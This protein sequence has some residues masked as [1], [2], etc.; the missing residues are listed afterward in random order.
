MFTTLI[1]AEDLQS[2]GND[3]II[4]DCRGR[5]GDPAFG[6]AAY[7]AGHLPGAC[8]ASLDDDFADAPGAGGRHPLPDPERLAARLRRWGVSDSDQ[9]VAY[10]DAGGAFAARIWWCIRSLGHAAVAVLDG[11]I[12]A[13][14]GPLS[15]DPAEPTPGSFSIRP[16][17]TRTVSA[18][19]VQQRGAGVCLVDARSEARFRGEEEPIDPVAGHIPGAVC[20]PFQGNLGADGRFLPPDALA[21]RFRDLPDSLICYCGSGVTA[22][23]DVLALRIAGREEPALYPGS[24]S[25][26]IRD[27]A[28]PIATGDDT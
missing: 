18:D 15:Q 19:D 8:Y 4:L 10:D 1:S 11:G 21:A 2:L 14:P 3:V 24:W 28:R 13:W 7:A 5:L 22:A 12:Q 9:V 16:P 23:H 25:E 6:P 26:W 17:L 20:L 27:P